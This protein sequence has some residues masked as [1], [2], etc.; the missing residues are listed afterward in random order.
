M[1][2]EYTGNNLL[3]IDHELEKIKDFKSDDTEVTKDDVLSVTGMSKEYNVFTFQKA[4]SE[5][6]IK[7]SFLIAKN[8]MDSGENINLIISII[9]SFFKKSI[10]CFKTP[11]SQ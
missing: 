10:D 2:A 4:L 8:L 3:N 11:V 5:K 9:F 7:R 1:L 6:N